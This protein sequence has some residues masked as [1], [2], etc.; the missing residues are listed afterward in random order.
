LQTKP[1]FSYRTVTIALVSEYRLQDAGGARLS[2]RPDGEN[3]LSARVSR[4]A[5]CVRPPDIGQVGL[6]RDLDGH[7]AGRQSQSAR[8]WAYWDGTVMEQRGRNGWQRFGVAKAL[9]RVEL[10][11]NRCHRLLPAAVWIAW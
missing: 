4:L 6:L 5:Q 9:E 1:N 10:A 7:R 2:L 8:F 11:P 3:D